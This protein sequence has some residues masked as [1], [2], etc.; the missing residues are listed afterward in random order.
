MLRAGIALLVALTLLGCGKRGPPV[1]PERRIPSAVSDL[2]AVVEGRAVVLTWSKPGTRADGSRL[3]DLAAFRIYR[4]EEA[5]NGEPKP[6]MLSWGKVVGYEEV[7]VI[8]LADPTPAKAEGPR[9]SWADRDT[10]IFGRRYVYVVTALDSIGRSSPPS[11]RLVVPFL[12]APHPPDGLTAKAAEGEVR[13]G[14]SPPSLLVDGS[15]PP[16]PLDYELLRARSV[17]GPFQPVTP[18]P[19]VTAEFTDR[20]LENEQT[21]Y[22]A[23]RAVRRDPSGS[24]RSELSAVIAATPLDLTPPSRPANLVA[25]PSETAVRLAWN[26]SPEPDVAGYIVYRAAPGADFVRLTP[27]PISTTTYTDRAVGRGQTYTYV[28]TAVDRASR[29]NESQRS[30]PATATVP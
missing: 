8:R 11:S 28:V 7:A 26:A 18:E 29:A 25:V 1:A 4:R 15:P 14:W 27:T 3:K 30:A 2:S 23:V 9:V 19:I 17:E 22:Y 13:L 20:G 21:Y 24:A 16:T 12:A 5:G 10:L 6:A